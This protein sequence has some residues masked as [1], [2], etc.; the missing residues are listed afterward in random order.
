MAEIQIFTM[1]HC[2]I[3]VMIGVKML[4]YFLLVLVIKCDVGNMLEKLVLELGCF[5]CG[6]LVNISPNPLVNI[7]GL[8][9]TKPNNITR[10]VITNEL[11][12]IFCKFAL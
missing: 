10:T 2:V 6:S 1:S 3:V 5:N 7:V 11:W 12:L 9:S 8:E 4:K